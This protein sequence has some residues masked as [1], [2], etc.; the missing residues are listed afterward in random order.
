MANQTETAKAEASWKTLGGLLG[1]PSPRVGPEEIAVFTRQLST[2]L[3][4]GIPLMESLDVLAEQQTDPG[5]TRV[6]NEIVEHVRGG[7]DFS[8]ALEDYPGL[9]TRIYVS[10]VEAGEAS[11]NLDT[12]LDRLAG[13]LESAEQLKREIKSAMTYPV[14]S[15]GLIFLIAGGLMFFIVP[16]FKK[17]FET[18]GMELPWITKFILNLSIFLKSNVLPMLGALAVIGVLFYFWK[19]SDW[20]ERQFHWI[21]LKVPIFGPLF[22]KV[23]IARFTQTYATLIRSGVPILG[24]LEITATTAGNRIIEDAVLDAKE[25]VRQGEQLG[26]PLEETGVFPVMVT[27]MISIGEKAGALEDLLDKIAEFYNQQVES[28][29]QQLTSL[30]EPLLIS[31]MGIV[32]GGIVLAIFLPILNIQEAVQ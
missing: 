12:V 9:F 28:T 18:I 23:A 30:I 24:A 7:G 25:E 26:E 16:K 15:L 4:A 3:G 21:L 2:M 13:Y 32:V 10:M 19:N 20:G 6:L 8:S 31:V 5:F 29:V 11:G 14:V 17:I 27:K 1:P 22:R